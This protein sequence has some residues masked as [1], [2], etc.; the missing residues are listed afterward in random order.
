MNSYLENVWYMAGW[1]KDL[2]DAP[3]AREF[4][5]TPVV[6]FRDS[7]G[8]PRALYD[9]CPHRFAPL[10]RGTLM[11][12]EIVCG[13]HGLRFAGDGRCTHNPWT[14]RIPPSAQVRAFPMVEQDG[15]LWIWLGDRDKADPDRI[16]RYPELADE[17]FRFV[18]GYSHVNA[19]YELVTDNL[20]DLL[21]SPYLH[22]GFGTDWRPDYKCRVEGDTVYSDYLVPPYQGSG[23]TDILWPQTKGKMVDDFEFMR[24]NA[25]SV[26]ELRIFIGIDGMKV[27][28]GKGFINIAPHILT[29]GNETSAHYFW[30]SGIKASESTVTDEAHLE[31]V[32]QAFDLEDAPMLEA[33]QR[34][35][36]EN[37]DIL[38]RK[39]RPVALPG[40]TS[41]VHARNILKKLIN[42]EKQNT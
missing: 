9:M 32:S 31:L 16:I 41:T 5:E 40:D 25:P 3:V 19:H 13:Y 11:E 8:T 37:T 29:P 39:P 2:K 38:A 4:L 36:G 14:G 33:V 20:L 23:F 6:I 42:R 34:R 17:N 21:H 15:I 18:F 10:S 1:G 12:G 30:A 28:E 7:F 27:T 24:W 22:P 35:L 26:L